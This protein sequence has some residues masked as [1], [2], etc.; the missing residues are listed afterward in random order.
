MYHPPAEAPLIV[1]RGNLPALRYLLEHGLDP[2]AVDAAG[3][4]LL[5]IAQEAG[6]AEA[7]A[8]LVAYGATRFVGPSPNA[9]AKGPE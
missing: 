5:A 7:A 9:V 8:M 2:G 6:Q 3:R 1:R 4:C